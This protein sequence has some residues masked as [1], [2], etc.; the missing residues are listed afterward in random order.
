MSRIR[1]TFIVAGLVVAMAALALTTQAQPPAGGRGGRNAGGR[2]QRGGP[3]GPGGFGNFNPFGNLV[4]L[5]NNEAVQKDLKVSETQKAAVKKLVED[6]NTRRR[7]SMQRMRQQTEQMRNQVGQ[8]A[9][10]QA[11][12]QQQLAAQAQQFD[13][14]GSGAGGA[15]EGALNSRGYQPQVYGGQVYGQNQVNPLMQQQAAIAQGKMAANAARQQGFMMMRQAQQQIQ[16]QAERDLA[17]ILSGAQMKRLKE[18]QLQ[19]EG[20][21]AVLRPDVAPRLDITEEQ[22]AEIQQVVAEAGQMRRQLM[23]KNFQF[24]RSIMPNGR[25]G[26]GPGGG[27]GGAPAAPGT[28]GRQRGGQGAQAGQPA[29]GGQAGQARQ[30][31]PGGRGQGGQN[32]PRFDPEA[33]RKVMEQPEVKAKMEDFRNEQAK[34]RDQEYAMVYKAMDRRQVSS[35]KKLL[36]KPFDVDSLTR[37]FFRGPGNGPE[38]AGATANNTT[39]PAAAKADAAPKAEETPSAAAKPA[40][41]RPSLRERRGLAPSPS[42][43]SPK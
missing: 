7:D 14:R 32:R 9:Q 17:K 18:I 43:D 12:Q 26:N 5:A 30:G 15:L 6:E 40:S 3:G 22:A 27:G 24:I 33:M 28:N 39:Q 35:F 29:Q 37:G 11:L 23:T 13:T 41:R 8:Q 10:A 20:P 21:G 2:G 16:Q 19:A 38:G 31:G 4:T 34:L 25:G 1:V 36:G 42:A